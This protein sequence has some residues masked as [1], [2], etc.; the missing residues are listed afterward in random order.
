MTPPVATPQV[1][2]ASSDFTSTPWPYFAGGF[3]LFAFAIFSFVAALGSRTGPMQLHLSTTLPSIVAVGL[4]STGYRLARSPRE[5]EVGEERLVVRSRRG[6][7]V[8]RWEDVA[9]ADVQ[10][11]AMTNRQ[12]LVV[13]GNDGR[14]LLRLPSNL[15]PF[16][17][18]TEAVRGRLTA[19]P[20][21]HSSDVQWRKSRRNAV[22]FLFLAVFAAAGGGFMGWTGY[23]ERRDAQLMDTR[24]VDGEGLVVRKFVAPD[25]RTHRIEYRVAGAG[26]DAYLHNVE[27]DPRVWLLL[28]SG[29]RLPIK[30]VPGHPEIARL[31]AGEIADDF[32]NL[33]PL[34]SALFAA[35]LVVMSLVF[36]AG[37][38]LAFR[39]IDIATDPVTGR[40][41]VNRLPAKTK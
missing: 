7:Q 36:A 25:G 26:D 14:A 32:H 27:V 40:L 38:F 9:W 16:Q 11:Q 23:T 30:T 31:R 37:A 33:P 3:A 28:E 8:L 19:R 18:L 4:I 17:W 20:S 24:G 2:R 22:F 6:E 1:F 12:V 29:S 5:V 21:P 34:I 15:E 10:T 41:K 39:G 35:A 13:Y